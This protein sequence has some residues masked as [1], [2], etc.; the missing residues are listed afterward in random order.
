M[1]HITCQ[2]K[3]KNPPNF[4]S[5][6]SINVDLISGVW[7]KKRRTMFKNSK[8][9]GLGKDLPGLGYHTGT[10]SSIGSDMSD[11]LS[12]PESHVSFEWSVRIVVITVQ[13]LY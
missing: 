13:L 12:S 4:I 8:T 9:T 6:N 7:Q 5:I 3:K 11:P 2:K 1:S 10:S